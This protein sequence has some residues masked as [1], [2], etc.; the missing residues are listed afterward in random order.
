MYT[1]K[2]NSASGNQFQTGSNE[3]QVLDTSI[4][5]NALRQRSAQANSLQLQKQKQAADKQDDLL[6]TIA[7]AGAAKI[8]PGDLDYFKKGSA[9][10]Y[11]N[12]TSY[13]DSDGNISTDNYMKL[14]AQANQ[15]STEADMSK[16]QRE[17]I[18]SENAK[19]DPTKHY[20]EEYSKN[21]ELYTTEGNWGQSHAL[22]EMQDVTKH[23]KSNLFPF[24]KEKVNT[25]DIG[26][27]YFTKDQAAKELTKDF[28]SNPS[29][30]RQL[31]RDVRQQNPN[32][33][34]ADALNHYINTQA[35]NLTIHQTVQPSASWAN[36]NANQ[37]AKQ[38]TVTEIPPSTT[39]GEGTYVVDKTNIP[40]DKVVQN[41]TI[42]G[43]NV[44]G[45]L[46]EV[47]YKIEDGKKVITGGTLIPFLTEE[48]KQTIAENKV[49]K[50]Q[51]NS[52]MEVYE[53]NHP[54]PKADDY[55]S[56]EKMDAAIT[57]WGDGLP[58]LSSVRYKQEPVNDKPIKID[59][60]QAVSI[61]FNKYGLNIPELAETGSTDANILKIENDKK[62]SGSTWEYNGDSASESEWLANGWTLDQLKKHAKKK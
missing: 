23:V 55:N 39:D 15:L 1:I 41:L 4:T 57:E 43:K 16:N 51:W 31:L 45:T 29:I 60:N 38:P 11:K 13:F 25:G 40:A 49:K 12:A 36:F 33:T 10:L 54:R 58:K 5:E 17:R 28:E 26:T 27:T 6:K 53:K 47:K 46:G 32:A 7:K 37:S 14:L 59:K 34:E 50:A 18:E 8:K 44:A 22:Q 35:H 24:V 3:D 61:A 30:K 42:G 19:Y 21:N 48:D 62:N 52:D 9:D 56:K 20:G 2:D